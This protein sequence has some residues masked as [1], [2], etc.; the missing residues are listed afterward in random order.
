MAYQP[1][2]RLSHHRTPA[3]VPCVKSLVLWDID[4][5]LVRTRGVATAAF[6]RAVATYAGLDETGFGQPEIAG[7]TDRLIASDWL[8]LAGSDN[9]DEAVDAVL[10]L[11]EKEL[12]RSRDQLATRSQIC[13]GVRQLLSALAERGVVQSVCTGNIPANARLKLEVVGLADWI[14]WEIGAYGDR[15]LDRRELAPIALEA[16]RALRNL[17]PDR[18]W[19]IGDTPRDLACA[20]AACVSSLLVA[21]GPYSAEELARLGP[22]ACLE[23]L[24]QTELA[25][26]ILAG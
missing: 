16:A 24:S 14:D 18:V 10:R 20:Q 19:I 12:A 22:D 11:Y 13:P 26:S 4:G 23:N 2:L 8:A 15:H 9:S 21:T 25:M 7:K 1:G 3:T 17:E 6:R 5:T